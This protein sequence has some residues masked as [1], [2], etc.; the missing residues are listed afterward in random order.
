MSRQVFSKGVRRKTETAIGQ[1]MGNA[2]RK[3]GFDSFDE[4]EGIVGVQMD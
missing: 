4:I 1:N 2:K 3:V